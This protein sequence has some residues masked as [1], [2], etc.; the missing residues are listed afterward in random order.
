MRPPTAQAELIFSSPTIAAFSGAESALEA[1][2]I[3]VGEGANHKL[4]ADRPELVVTAALH[5]AEITTAAS[6]RGVGDQNPRRTIE[7]KRVF[8]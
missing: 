1:A 6:G 5:G 7:S 2:E 3:V 8:S 4:L